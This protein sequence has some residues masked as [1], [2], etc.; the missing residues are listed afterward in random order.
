[1]ALF[2]LQKKGEFRVHSLLTTL[3]KDHQRVSMHGVRES[4][5]NAQAEALGIP[6]KKVFLPAST[7][8]D[9]YNS[10]MKD[11]MHGFREEGILHGA[12]GDLFLEDLR[13]FR[14]EKMLAAGMQAVFPVWQA[15]T[16][17]FAK[18]VIQA[19]FKAVVVCV[20]GD[21]L[22][23]EFSGRDYDQSFLN[24][25]PADVDPCGENGEFHTCVVDGPVFKHPVDFEKG[26]VVCK[27]YQRPAGSDDPGPEQIPFWF[28]DLLPGKSF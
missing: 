5:L 10:I 22:P 27:T 23:R 12:F 16:T 6:L 2:A 4:I 9:A 17:A 25:L 8:H 28:C 11:V 15:D 3:S 21:K 20:N 24:D 7:D 26:E 14:E 1:M 13:K 18:D 19:G